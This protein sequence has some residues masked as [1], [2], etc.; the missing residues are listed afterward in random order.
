MGKASVSFL[1]PIARS[2]LRGVAGFLFSLHGFQKLFAM[3]GGMGGGGGKAEFLSLSW[4]A[5]V[6][7]TVGGIL[8]L[9]GLMTRPA[10]F[11][12]SGMMAVAYFMSH[13]PRGHWPILN[14][15]DLAALY[16]FVFLWLASAGAGPLSVDRVL[17]R[18]T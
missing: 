13:A 16:S 8:I 18:K 10:A 3:F 12:L 14:G 2:V 17:G 9:I 1:E 6:L 11:V 5:G 15:G 4:T 7:E